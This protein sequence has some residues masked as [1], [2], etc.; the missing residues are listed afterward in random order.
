MFL[1]WVRASLRDTNATYGVFLMEV[2]RVIDWHCTEPACYA[3]YFTSF[4]NYALKATAPQVTD[5]CVSDTSQA[6]S[7]YTSS[8][9]FSVTQATE[10]PF[11]LS[12]TGTIPAVH[13]L[14]SIVAR[15]ACSFSR[16]FF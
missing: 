6:S 15:S 16:S 11:V 10:V 12:M 7:D 3:P 1:P 9:A 8:S 14:F 5:R 4:V 13:R 2:D